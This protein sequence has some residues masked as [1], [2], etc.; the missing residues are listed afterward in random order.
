MLFVIRDH[1]GHTPLSNLQATLTTDLHRLWDN[2]SKPPGLESCSITTFFDL[3][4]VTLPHKQLV[5]DKFIAEIRQLRQLFI[6]PTRPDYVF[7]DKYHKRIPADGISQYMETIWVR[8]FASAD[9]LDIASD[10]LRRRFEYTQDAVITNK[11]LDLPTQQEL[12]AQFRCDEIASVAFAA[13][14]E[15]VK[16]FVQPNAAAAT[17]KVVVGLGATME[18][19][20][21]NALGEFRC[22][23]GILLHVCMLTSSGTT[24]SFDT[25]ASRYH[26]T[27][28]TRKRLELVTKLNSTLH[29]Y[30][31]A[32]LKSLH[33]TLLREYRKSI[34][35]G[36]RTEG[37]DFGAV[38]RENMERA[39]KE[40]EA[41]EKECRL[42]LTEWSGE[43]SEGMLKEDMI[44]IADLLRAEET[45]KMIMI[46]E[47]SLLPVMS[48][49]PVLCYYLK[50]V[51]LIPQ[52]TLL[53]E[54]PA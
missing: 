4:F 33:K 35:D 43:E 48:R 15:E 14:V 18:K 40:F 16:H 9:S 39:E 3:A 53:L 42:E 11:D 29:P 24:V 32:Q 2:L 7:Q 31:L 20:R 10:C 51:S 46:I 45:R 6:D 47:V 50:L 30:Y 41:G 54:T 1:I 34:Q 22:A 5:P 49:L 17:G 28:Y 8:S 21:S 25:S 13:F 27:V 23:C 12:L 19:T 36:L 38:V 44:A 52:L 26:S 37:Y